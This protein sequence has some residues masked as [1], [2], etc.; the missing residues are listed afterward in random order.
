MYAVYLGVDAA[1]EISLHKQREGASTVLAAAHVER[2]AFAVVE[3]AVSL[4]HRPAE[5]DEIDG[6]LF[7]VRIPVDV[8]VGPR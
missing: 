8:G 6:T 5:K 2:V 3:G 7:P 1:L 4:R